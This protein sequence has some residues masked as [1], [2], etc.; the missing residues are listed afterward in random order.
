MWRMSPHCPRGAMFALWRWL[1]YLED[2]SR[3]QLD[4]LQAGTLFAQ[5]PALPHLVSP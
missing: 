2:R 3:R 1:S 4:H 5:W